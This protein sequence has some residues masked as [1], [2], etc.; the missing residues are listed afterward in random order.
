MSPS[1]QRLLGVFEFIADAFYL[2]MATICGI[3]L[4]GIVLGA[5]PAGAAL[6]G[7]AADRAAGKSDRHIWLS[8]WS[9]YFKNFWSANRVCLPAFMIVGFLI[10]DFF[11]VRSH[12]PHPWALVGQAIIGAFIAL[13]G[14]AVTHLL[15]EQSDSGF[16]SYQRALSLALREPLRNLG[17]LT[18]TFLLLRISL[19]IVGF[20]ALLAPG[21]WA[22]VLASLNRLLDKRYDLS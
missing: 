18:V 21:L 15:F 10:Y 1:W 12:L 14:L 19:A 3:L 6:A 22:L 4:G 8:F 11:L 13:F 9:R 5:A 20:G 16:I 17:Y 2:S 7:S